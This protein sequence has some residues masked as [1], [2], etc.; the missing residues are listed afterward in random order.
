MD[1]EPEARAEAD[2]TR[3]ACGRVGYRREIIMKCLGLGERALWENGSTGKSDSERVRV[4]PSSIRICLSRSESLTPKSPTIIA[5]IQGLAGPARPAR[6]AGSALAF[7]RCGDV[8]IVI[9]CQWGGGADVI[10]DEI[11]D[12]IADVIA[13]SPGQR[14]AYLYRCVVSVISTRTR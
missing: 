12:E 8:A 9:A 14:P 1:S 11:A 6:S 3:K 5:L 4:D 2:G 13:A 7:R 10:A